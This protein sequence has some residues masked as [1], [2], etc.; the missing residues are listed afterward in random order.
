MFENVTIEPSP[1]GCSGGLSPPSSDRINNYVDISNYIMLELGH[2]THPFDADKLASDEIIVRLAEPGET[3][4]TIDHVDR[5]LDGESL[6]IADRDRAVAIAGI[7][8]GVDTE[9]S[10]ETNRVLLESAWF[11]SKSI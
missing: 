10:D 4:M 7:M 8:G 1:D 5:E 9:V 11:E 2:P 6:V 3:I